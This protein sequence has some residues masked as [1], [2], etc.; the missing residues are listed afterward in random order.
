VAALDLLREAFS[1][2][3]KRVRRALA[4]GAKGRQA[5]IASDRVEPGTGVGR[6]GRCVSL[7]VRG[8]KCLL[9]SVL[10][11]FLTAE[12]VTA[13]RE[14]ARVVALVEDLEGRVMAVPNRG[15]EPLIFEL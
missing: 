6:R 14:D 11:V 7:L 3:L 10:G 5:A 4:P 1:S 8:Q 13:E 9:Y 12:H 2:G 15:N